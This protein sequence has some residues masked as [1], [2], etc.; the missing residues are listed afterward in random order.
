VTGN[1]TT[2]SK[3]QWGLGLV[4][5]VVAWLIPY[6]WPLY[7]SAVLILG[8][9]LLHGCYDLTIMRR[10][11]TK[12]GLEFAPILIAY[13]GILM[14]M[15]L[16]FLALPFYTLLLFLL[17]SAY[18][19]GEQNWSPRIDIASWTSRLFVLAYGGFILSLLF[20]LN[21]ATS[22]A[23]IKDLTGKLISDEVFLYMAVSS[24]IVMFLAFLLV[25]HR[26]SPKS[27]LHE[28]AHL[29]LIVATFYLLDVFVAFA[30]YFSV[31]HSLPSI[32]EQI[33]RTKNKLSLSTIWQYVKDSMIIYVIS[34][35]GVAGMV[36]YLS[37]EVTHFENFV[38][39]PFIAVTT[40]HTLLFAAFLSQK[41]EGNITPDGS[42]A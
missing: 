10:V 16:L 42:T 21:T 37:D 28:F 29:T 12:K 31:W 40:A 19:F 36:W 5:L 20:F 9:G 3:I 33:T 30:V 4:T 18:H 22:S 25:F 11:A 24:F 34:L 1:Y 35:A 13:L 7:F 2:F 6:H 27:M 41:R 8:I 38:L 32:Y 14:F 39:S 15:V 17:L 26:L 23:L